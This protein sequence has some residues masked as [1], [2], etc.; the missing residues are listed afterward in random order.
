MHGRRLDPLRET[1]LVN[2]TFLLLAITY[3]GHFI[4]VHFL[5]TDSTI[6]PPIFLNGVFSLLWLLGVE[7]ALN[8][9]SHCFYVIL[10]L[11]YSIIHSINLILFFEFVLIESC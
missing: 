9:F 1:A 3:I 11:Y 4:G 6:D 5:E 8:M 2:A 7:F 10:N